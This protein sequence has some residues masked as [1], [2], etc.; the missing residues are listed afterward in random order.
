MTQSE[1]W[2]WQP[3]SGRISATELAR[4]MRVYT[5]EIP[6]NA[7]G[8]NELHRWSLVNEESFW[9]NL[10]QHA[11][12]QGNMGIESATNTGQAEKTT[13]FPQAQVN[14]AEN[15][16][17]HADRVPDNDAIV[18]QAESQFGARI[19][20]RE[21]VR[22]VVQVSAYLKN[23]DVGPG[24]VVAGYIPNIPGA[25]V[26][27]L[28]TTAIGAVWTSTSPDFGVDSVIDR[29]GQTKPKV[30]FSA[31]GY[32]YNGKA[33]SSRAKSAE[34]V[35]AVP[36]IRHWV[37]VPFIELGQGCDSAEAAGALPEDWLGILSKPEVTPLEFKRQSFSAPLFILYSSGT[38]G[39]PKCIVHSTGGILL[40]HIKEHQLH[41][42]VQPGD[43][44]FFFT[45]CGWMM[46][47]WL[48]SALASGATLYLYEGSPFAKK[49]TVLWDW[50]EKEQITLF[51][52]SPK[53]LE[54][55]ERAQL[56]PAENY[57]LS[58]L[59]TICSTG[60]VLAPEQF[61]FV[62]QHIKRDVHLASI[63]GGTDICGCFAL[64]NPISP[65]YRG[66][67][68]GPGLA[69]D[70]QVFDD[71][72][73]ALSGQKGELVCCNGFV[74]RPLGFWKDN[75]DKYHAAYWGRYPGVWHHGDLVAKTPG[76]G[77]VFYGR[78]DAV[79]NPGGVRIGTAEI[80]RQVQKFS[81]IEN[82]VVIGQNWN[83]DV[84]VVLFVQLSQ[85]EILTSELCAE[86]RAK[87]KQ[88]CTP[89]HI[90]AKIL[91][92]TDIP[93]TRSGKIVELAA[94]NVVHGETVHNI[95]SLQNPEALD[96]FRNR[97]ELQA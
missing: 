79:L 47:N 26:A 22:Q 52:T 23:C 9:Q 14:Y 82:S 25:I 16:L 60:S 65:V 12:L 93:R 50:V 97:N 49:G 5:P 87:I 74:N 69:M 59:K 38:T 88:E 55:V 33:F 10:W 81:E 4:Y 57:D 76:G 8:Y 43:K 83:N 35:A 68:Q 54:A 95:G 80:Y 63:S 78:S 11:D 96:S 91:A 18:F 24:D 56:E 1:K 13:W 58:S 40:N 19:S 20:W 3:S 51:G 53:Y 70:V 2:L 39:K 27:M 7:D 92:V 73:N 21:L 15:L 84:R 61:D 41:C 32:I 44:V 89:R 37:E 72:G 90:P 28:A 86:I 17:R 66:T 62:Y 64:G 48:V 85:D 67:I 6:L 77:L 30:L 31:S 75:G 45:T 46:W 29:F 34:I 71:K 42:D 36:A 94:R